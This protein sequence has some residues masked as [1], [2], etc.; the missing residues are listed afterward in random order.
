M[1]VFTIK[2]LENLSGI[3]AHTIRIW[4]QR[5]GFLKPQRT[6][7][8]IRFYTNEE[9]KT[10]LNISLLNKHGFK[11]SRLDKMKPEE[12]KE[13]IFALSEAD[14]VKERVINE[15]VKLMIDLDMCV[16]DNVLKEQIA[17][18]GMEKGVME[19]IFPFLERVGLLWQTG[20]INPAQEHLVS[21]II[22]QKLIVAIDG[23]PTPEMPLKK[24]M[25]FLPEGEFHEVGLL[26][27][28]YLLKVRGIETIYLGSN[29]PQADASFVLNLKRPDFAFIHLTTAATDFQFDAYIQNISDCFSGTPTIVSGYFSQHYQQTPPQNIHLMSSVEDVLHFIAHI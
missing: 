6:D 12:I 16:F 7:T 15:L 21:N 4:E 18:I 25:L 9:L 11:I 22:R 1:E 28:N 20:H 27:M 23:C 10:L 19:V 2:D 14:A 29:V 5:Y 3:K 17:A 24:A 13:K 8:N 26:Y